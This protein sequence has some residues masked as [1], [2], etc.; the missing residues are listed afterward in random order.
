[1]TP[2]CKWPI[3]SV[4]QS[5]DS[6]TKVDKVHRFIESTCPQS[7]QVHRSTGPQSPQVHG[8]TDSQVHRS[9]VSFEINWRFLTGLRFEREAL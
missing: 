2:S 5:V 3:E 8:S 7:P 1:M 9:S 6:S 4:G